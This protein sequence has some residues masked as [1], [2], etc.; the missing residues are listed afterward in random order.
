MAGHVIDVMVALLG[1]PQQV[2]PFLAHH[3]KEAP[4]SYVDHG[5]AVFTYPHAWGLVEVP[6]LEVAPHARRVEVYGT[7]GAHVIPHLGSGHLANKDVQ[8]IELYREGKADW[9]RLD[10]PAAT[11][12]IGD[13]R[14]FAACV[15]RK[16]E[17]QY[18]L[19]HDLAVQETLL[20]ASGMLGGRP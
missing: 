16:K 18:S 4:A 13:L 10:L 3:H 5:V 14:E 7:A 1:K 19:Q 9:D 11:L 8:P 12:Q 20:R 15:T 17:P 6:A 2:T